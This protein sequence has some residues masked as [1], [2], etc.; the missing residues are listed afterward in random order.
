MTGVGEKLKDEVCVMFC[1][2]T[3]LLRSSEVRRCS[4]MVSE[5]CLSECKEDN[6]WYQQA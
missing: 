2:E 6:Q 5:G 1:A 4:S 3:S